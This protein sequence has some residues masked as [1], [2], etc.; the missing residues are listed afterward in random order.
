MFFLFSIPLA[1]LAL[2]SFVSYTLYTQQMRGELYREYGSNLEQ[3][4]DRIARTLE[5]INRSVL[6]LQKFDDVETVLGETG[7]LWEVDPR[8]VRR[9][10]E[11]LGNYGHTRDIVGEIWVYFRESSVVLSTGGAV[12]E[13]LFFETVHKFERYD[14]SYW[15]SIPFR[16]SSSLQLLAPSFLEDEFQHGTYIPLV[17]SGIGPS[18]ARNLVVVELDVDALKA[19]FAPYL[20]TDDSSLFFTD[21]KGTPYIVAATGDATVADVDIARIAD[22]LDAT[23]GIQQVRNGNDLVIVH[24]IEIFRDPYVLAAV[25]PS[26]AIR[27]RTAALGTT[28]LTLLSAGLLVSLLLAYVFSRRLYAPLQRLIRRVERQGG[29]EDAR[30][31][32]EYAYLMSRMDHLFSREQELR[33]DLSQALPLAYE[34]CLVQIVRNGNLEYETELRAFLRERGNDFSYE[35]FVVILIRYDYSKGYYKTFSVQSELELQS[36]V[37][38]LLSTALGTRAQVYPLRLESHIQCVVAN[39]ANGVEP[40]TL[41]QQMERLIGHLDVPHDLI[42]LNVAIGLRHLG[43]A[44]IPQSFRE[45]RHR[46]SLMIEPDSQVQ[47][48]SGESRNSYVLDRDVERRIENSLRIGSASQAIGLLE[49]VVAQNSSASTGESA[50][51]ALYLHL[52]SVTSQIGGQTG[53]N[54]G[55]AVPNFPLE[56]LPVYELH[57]LLVEH[58][59]AVAR[60][61]GDKRHAADIQQVT[62]Y[63]Q[64]NYD[65]DI[66]LEGLADQFGVSYKHLSHRI[67]GYLG[68]PFQTYLAGIRVERAKELLSTTDLPISEIAAS[69]G[70]ESQSTFFRVFKKRE[71]ITA[72]EYRRAR[73]GSKAGSSEE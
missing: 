69:V 60:T 39:V 49:E 63:I 8:I 33:H 45:A 43:I 48:Y 44:G 18:I 64:T 37:S 2:I 1:F 22:R 62:D 72:G 73:R 31:G 26:S 13:Q 15:Q 58:F 46:L 41:Q 6:F 40:E 25:V 59:E 52:Q 28:V 36:A 32:D 12:G 17:F 16:H 14:I 51:R 10:A 21:G 35:N 47:V 42:R 50:M 61:I 19:I 38:G 29:G 55:E 11:A 27:A 7:N 56:E 67:K 3:L 30:S 4:A 53:G 65:Q 34:R 68:I 20:F 54:D 23:S 24:P 71:G 66:Y 9:A 5:E 70:Y 57:R